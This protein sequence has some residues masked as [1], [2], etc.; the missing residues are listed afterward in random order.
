MSNIESILI[1]NNQSTMK[2]LI[3]D[4][5]R[6]MNLIRILLISI[7]LIFR[8]RITWMKTKKIM[9]ILIFPGIVTP[10]SGVKFSKNR[11]EV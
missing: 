4:M 10:D 9:V 7:L 2:I 5:R 3:K 1:V 8:V 11:E 6:R